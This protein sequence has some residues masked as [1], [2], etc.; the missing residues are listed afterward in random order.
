V[1]FVHSGMH[2]VMPRGALLPRAGREV[3]V[4]VGEPVEV[5]DLLAA[6]RREGWPE[7]D[8]YRAVSARVGLALQRLKARLDGSPLAEGDVAALAAEQAGAAGLDL[9]DPRD[10]HANRAGRAGGWRSGG[11]ARW[12]ASLAERIEF[13]ASHR[14]FAAAGAAA[15][16]AERAG[17][18]CGGGGGGGSA[19]AAAAWHAAGGGWASWAAAG[20]LPAWSA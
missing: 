19:A 16:A 8:L 1:P 17:L 13:R 9:Y 18:A 4:L 7:D 15:A 3:R 11:A 5:A 14:G 20:P 12:A 2:E 6:A 10:R